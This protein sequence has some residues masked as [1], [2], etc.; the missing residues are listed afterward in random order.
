MSKTTVAELQ[1]LPGVSPAKDVAT[2]GFM[3]QQTMLRIRDPNSRYASNSSKCVPN[4]F[5]LRREP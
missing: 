1:A 4:W 5:W 2:N 3:L